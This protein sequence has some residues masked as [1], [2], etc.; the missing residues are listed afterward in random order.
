[1]V[2][3]AGSPTLEFQ[4]VKD[5][6]NQ[7][8]D[9][10]R[11]SGAIIT[12]LVLKDILGADSGD[13]SLLVSDPVETLSTPSTALVVIDP[14]ITNQPVSVVENEGA[15]VSFRVGAYGTA[16]SYQWL[17]GTTPIFDATNLILSLTGISSSDQAEYRVTISNSY[18]AVSSAIAFL[19]VIISPL[20]VLS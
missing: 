8:S 16:L 19:I 17:K 15:S 11:I 4:W 7:L 13:Y 9:S 3:V 14:V 12:Q 5:G 10:A 1:V 2:E 6:T 18:G 20:F